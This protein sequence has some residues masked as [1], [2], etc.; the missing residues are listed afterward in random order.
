MPK[1][2]GFGLRLRRAVARLG[3]TSRGQRWLAGCGGWSGAETATTG[4][5]QT[6]RCETERD[7]DGD[8][9]GAGAP[10]PCVG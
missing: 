5:P 8:T 6:G 1:P 2:G 10:H 9:I 7:G 4:A 3:G